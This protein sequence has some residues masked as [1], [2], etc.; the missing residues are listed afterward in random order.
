MN[1]P[2]TGYQKITFQYDSSG[3][4]VGNLYYDR[5]GNSVVDKRFDRPSPRRLLRL[6]LGLR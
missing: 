5:D 6:A 4:T 1:Q 2:D 3:R